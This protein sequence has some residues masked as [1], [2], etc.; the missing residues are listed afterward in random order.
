MRRRNR[1]ETYVEA[2][3]RGPYDE[4]PMLE[5]GVDPQLHLS[6]ND[7]PQP[8]FLV[9]E[10][11]CVIAQMSG[12]ARV[13]FRSSSV[14]YFDLQLGDFV[15]VPA[16]TPH[17]IVPKTES[18]HLRYK[19]AEAGLEAVAWYSPKT[20]EEITRVTWDCAQ[21]LPQE[22]YLRACRAFND[23]ERMRTCPTTG[24]VLPPIDL[25]PYG[26]EALAG[27][28]RDAEAA[29]RERLTAQGEP[30]PNE[31]ARRPSSS[32]IAAAAEDKAPLKNNVY[33]YARTAHAALSPLFPY[34]D[35]G[36]IVPC[37]ALQDLK[38][39]GSRGYFVHVNT[40]Q[41][42]NVCF[43]VRGMSYLQ[44]GTAVVGPLT[45]PVGD[46]PGQL[47]D[48]NV[49]VLPVITQR[50]AVGIPQT[51]SVIYPCDRCGEEVFRR[52][53]RAHDFPDPLAG[54]VDPQIVGL[55]TIAQSAATAQAFNDVV[56]N[57]TCRKCGHV[58]APFPVGYWGWEEYRRRTQVSVEARGIMQS[59]VRQA[60][61]K[62]DAA[63]VAAG[64]ATRLDAG[65]TLPAD[66]VF[67]PVLSVTDVRPG[68]AR[69]ATVGDLE[70]AIYNLD[71]RFYASEGYCTHGHAHL[72]SGYVDGAL[73][74]CRM[75][76]GTF[77][78]PTG[79]AVGA[80]CT[81]DL[82]TYKVKVEGDRILVA[83]P[84]QVP[85]RASG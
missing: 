5:L 11:D 7:R 17:R 67:H 18:I 35:E 74:E 6:R 14:N 51:E 26:W 82:K 10:Q 24:A 55:P 43:G 57:R 47:P 34:F 16:G 9:C 68:Q 19:A 8:F 33:D 84:R 20:G 49:I 46:K 58:S 32:R 78:I 81:I 85:A 28:I 73:I 12:A 50:Q 76:G 61:P 63:A 79:K 71:G 27:E 56:E 83:V 52:D 64:P 72:G 37:V 13:E 23:S 42:V 60:R 54:D 25:A 38:G 80:P 1:F 66:D 30:L 62:A 15:Y 70:L 39:R 75:H 29:E 22:G 3:V 36:C 53:Y 44:P 21:E 31:R 59:A 48:P 77:D 41:E 4:C 40:V 45:H 65:D 69:R 2:A